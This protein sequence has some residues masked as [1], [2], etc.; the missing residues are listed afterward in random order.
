M[1]RTGLLSSLIGILLVI[2]GIYSLFSPVAT[3]T[4]IPYAIGLALIATGIG[5]VLRRAEE[6]RFYGES[7]WSLAGAIVSLLFGIVLVLSPALQLSMGVS[8]VMLIGCWITVMGVL[9][10]VHAFRLRRVTG[11]T[12]LFG[13]PVSH[14]WYMALLP[15]AAMV[16]F[17]MVNVLKPAVGLG[18][19]G[20]LLGVLMIFCGSSLLSLGSFSWYW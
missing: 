5:K 7:R 12:D 8:V 4:V 11:Y 13:R 14:D 3:S 2:A 6:R 1:R 10:I 9:R 15:G 19:I 16:I 17:G 18:M 20:T